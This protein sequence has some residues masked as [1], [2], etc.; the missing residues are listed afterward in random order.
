M[1]ANHDRSKIAVCAEAASGAG[2]GFCY[3]DGGLNPE[4]D[5]QLDRSVTFSQGL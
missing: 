4:D 2:L 5:M 1:A 3:H